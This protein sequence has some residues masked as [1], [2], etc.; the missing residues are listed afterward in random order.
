MINILDLKNTH[1]LATLTHSY[2][3]QNQ[4][5]TASSYKKSKNY[6]SKL[7]FVCWNDRLLANIKDLSSA[8]HLAKKCKLYPDDAEAWLLL[9]LLQSKS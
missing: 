9:E 5:Q 7:S 1:F 6:R 4:Y 8:F 2:I 3:L